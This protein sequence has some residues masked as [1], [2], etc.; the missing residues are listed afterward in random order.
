LEITKT[1]RLPL[2]EGLENAADLPHT[3]SLAITYRER[4]NSFYELPKDKRPPRDLWDKPH[5][6]DD[7]FEEIFSSKGGG[8][9]SHTYV[10]YDNE[11]VE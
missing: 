1:T 8:N 5:R 6:L 10:E 4:I 11:E 3:I 9:K 7:F 2:D